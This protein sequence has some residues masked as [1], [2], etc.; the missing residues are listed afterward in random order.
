MAALLLLT[1]ARRRH[2]IEEFVVRA[3]PAARRPVDRVLGQ[4]KAE[5]AHVDLLAKVGV[6]FH[7]RAEPCHAAAIVGVARAYY[8]LYA[9]LAFVYSVT[10]FSSCR[11][12]AC[13]RFKEM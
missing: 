13:S 5:H 7:C 6:P 11:C 8:W 10:S 12:D 9:A 4:A 2:L 3:L 1:E